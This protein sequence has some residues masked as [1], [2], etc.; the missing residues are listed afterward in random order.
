MSQQKLCKDCY[1]K[2]NC[3]EIY[4]HLGNVKGPSVAPQAV[5]AF[6]LPLMVFIVT[7]A[8]FAVFS[9]LTKNAD[10]IHILLALLPATSVALAVVLI[11]KAVR[12]K[13]DKPK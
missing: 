11:T 3:Q 9:D 7:L 8:A 13:L 12:R 1:Q 4:Q 2:D 5:I 6:L 10:H